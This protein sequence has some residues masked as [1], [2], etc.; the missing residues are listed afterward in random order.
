[1]KSRAIKTFLTEFPAIL[2]DEFPVGLYSLVLM[3]FSIKFI[4]DLNTY[5]THSTVQV[6]E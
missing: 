1:M 4:H 2:L 5:T 6:L 3:G